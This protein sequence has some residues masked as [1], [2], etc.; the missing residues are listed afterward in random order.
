MFVFSVASESEKN[1]EKY[2]IMELGSNSFVCEEGCF[3][4]WLRTGLL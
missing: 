2:E 4:T 1:E 3:Y